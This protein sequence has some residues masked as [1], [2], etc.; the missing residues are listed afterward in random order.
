MGDSYPHHGEVYAGLCLFKIPEKSYREY[1]AVKLQS[2]LDSAVEYSFSFFYRLSSLS[3]LEID[4][5]QILFTSEPL[6]LKANTNIKVTGGKVLQVEPG[7]QAGVKDWEQY[8]QKFISKGGEEYL[9]IGNFSHPDSVKYNTLND[10]K[11]PRVGR[12]EKVAYYYIDSFELIRVHKEDS[13]FEKEVIFQLRNLYFD[14]DKYQIKEEMLPELKELAEFMMKNLNLKLSIN[15]HTDNV[16]PEQ[17]NNELS[18]KRAIAV[19]DAIVLFGVPESQIITES[20]G[21]RFLT[22]NQDS[23]NRR[24]EFMLVEQSEY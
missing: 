4:H 11:Y 19:K 13:K 9:V 24:V 7:P 23:L 17:Y 6:S 1:L 22:S 14:F 2:P 18:L 12:I 21:K 20:H 16:G 10:R 3:K 15:G 5:F 8:S